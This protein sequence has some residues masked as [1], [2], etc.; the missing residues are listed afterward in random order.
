MVG[1]GWRRGDT[2]TS[3]PISERLALEW[4]CKPCAR[5][6]GDIELGGAASAWALGNVVFGVSARP[7]MST[8]KTAGAGVKRFPLGIR[9]CAEVEGARGEYSAVRSS[10]SRRRWSTAAGVCGP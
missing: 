5:L 3:H 4:R 9:K 8:I 7:S 2:P 10:R 1:E 6:L